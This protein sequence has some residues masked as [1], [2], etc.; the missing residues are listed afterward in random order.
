MSSSRTILLLGGTGDALK[1]ARTLSSQDV[2]SLA[3]L[4]KIPNDLICSVRTGGFGGPNK[5]TDYL[6]ELNI[7]LIIDA[8][9]PYAKRISENAVSSAYDAGV[10]CW[11]LRRKPWI[12]NIND[13]W[14]FVDDWPDINAMIRPF[15]RPFFTIGR[16]P[17][18]YLDKIPS[19]QFWLIRCLYPHPGN[20]LSKIIVEQGPFMIEDERFLIKNTGI[21]VIVSKNSGGIATKAKID[22]ARELGLP[23]VMLRR[24]LLPDSDLVFYSVDELIA[25]LHK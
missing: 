1:I 19:H 9:H 2:Y 11:S 20:I 25:A 12:Q 7:D 6:R 23:V 17:L 10:L 5:L 14:H 15:Y 22:V 16:E 13:D 8:T 24:P 4:G 3:G 21:D 18:M